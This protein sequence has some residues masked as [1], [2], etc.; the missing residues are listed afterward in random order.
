MPLEV[1]DSLSHVRYIKQAA[2]TVG[3]VLDGNHNLEIVLGKTKPIKW[4]TRTVDRVHVPEA[5]IRDTAAIFRDIQ[6]AVLAMPTRVEKGQ[7]QFERVVGAFCS[8][9][10][11][12]T[13]PIPEVVD[14]LASACYPW[15]ATPWASCRATHQLVTQVSRTSLLPFAWTLRDTVVRLDGFGHDLDQVRVWY[16]TDKATEILEKDTSASV[17]IMGL[18]LREENYLLY[19]QVWIRDQLQ[20]G[21]YRPAEITWLNYDRDNKKFW[22]SANSDYLESGTVV[23]YPPNEVRAVLLTRALNPRVDLSSSEE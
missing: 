23:T 16:P 22:V 10:P 11:G 4:D 21:L 9:L 18:C 3:R 8:R 1:A 6:V 12:A 20:G 14:R 2:S 13:V 5:D 15:N 19:G 17:R 7:E